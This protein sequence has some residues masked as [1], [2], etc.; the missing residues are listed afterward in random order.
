MLKLTQIWGARRVDFI[1]KYDLL[2]GR[3]AEYESVLVAYSGGIDSTLLAVAAHV[4][5]GHRCLAVLASSDTYP[6]HEVE[7]ASALASDLGLR[8]FQVETHELV[9]PKFRRNDI[10][11]CYYC[12]SELF[13]LLRTVADHKGLR[14]VV[15]G[16]NLDDLADFRPGTRAAKEYG[17]LSPMADAG[18]TKDDIRNIASSLGLPNWDKP[19][20]ACLASRF[21]Y[22][23]EITEGKLNRVAAAEAAI[24]ALGFR[25]LRVRAHSDLARLEVGPDEFERAWETRAEIASALKSAGFTFAAVDLEGYRSGSLNEGL[26]SEQREILLQL[27]GGHSAAI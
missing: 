7:Y 2:L 27:P 19:S 1:Q 8:L 23:E 3:L 21:P 10:D 16:S 4:V 17:V 11:R 5:H 20:M 22:G 26:D 9:D 13:S 25:Q 15:D 18:L 12:K 6:A 14:H 24:R